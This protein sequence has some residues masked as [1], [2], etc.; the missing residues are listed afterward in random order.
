MELIRIQS[1]SAPFADELISLYL[2]TFPANQRHN[3]ADFETLL[4]AKEQFYCCAVL[5]NNSLTG[6]INYWDFDQ[7]VYLEHLAIEP[8]LRGHKLG[9]KLVMLLREQAN[10]PIVLE[11][12]Y[13]EESEISARRIGFYRRLGFEVL[14]VEYMQPPYRKGE[15]AIPLVVLSDDVEYATSNFEMIRNRIYRE[16]YCVK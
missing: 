9:E 3:R 12:E 5:M 13:P 11:A 8:P 2:D 10:K 1:T 15:A 16:V 6:F 4:G 7:F 14:P